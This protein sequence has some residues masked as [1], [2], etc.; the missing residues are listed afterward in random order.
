MTDV[1]G[2]APSQIA[3]VNWQTIKAFLV[4][5]IVHLWMM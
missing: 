1:G 4:H 3:T 5:S 2:T